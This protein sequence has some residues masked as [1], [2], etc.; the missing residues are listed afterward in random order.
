MARYINDK[1]EIYDGVSVVAGGKRYVSPSEAKLLELG[2]TKVEPQPYEP[3]EQE[4]RTMR[5]GEIEALLAAGD[6]K[7]TKNSEAAAA[8][9]PL[10]YDPVE[11]HRERQA[12]RDE[13]NELEAEGGAQ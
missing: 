9:E 11:L 3:T 6:Y 8:G 7:V 1:G 13:Y 2:F 12:L 10:P 4:L 5:M